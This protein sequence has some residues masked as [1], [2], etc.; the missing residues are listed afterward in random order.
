LQRLIEV[1]RSLVSE[2]DLETVLRNLLDA[3]RDLTGAAYAAVG[4]LDEAKDSLER[5]VFVGI[6]EETRHAIG[7]LPRG[8]GVLGELIRHP[9]PLRLADVGAHEHS[10]GF[11]ANHPPM[12]TFLGTPVVIRGEAWG[13][14]Y[15]TE[16]AGGREFTDEDESLVIVLAAWAAVAIENAR[17]YEGL[18]ERRAELERVTRGLEISAGRSA[19]HRG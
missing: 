9:E 10:Y 2:L 6:D 4:I 18:D 8:R 12:K 13:N 16:K 15:L 17:L 1:G 5:F 19:G 3:A 11:P 7:P 14:L